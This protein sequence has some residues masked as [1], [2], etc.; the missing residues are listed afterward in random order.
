MCNLRI[1]SGTKWWGGLRIAFQQ[2]DRHLDVFGARASGFKLHQ[3]PV[4]QRIG[5]FGG[6]C[7]LGPVAD[8]F[9]GGALAGLP[10]DLLAVEL[11]LIAVKGRIKAEPVFAVLPDGE[12]ARGFAAAL[13]A[14]RAAYLRQDWDT[15][16]QGFA[17]IAAI[18]L[19]G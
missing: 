7:L 8:G 19:P 1:G 17:E 9:G 15:A 5:G 11:D 12:T 13:A 10:G 14:A 4:D 6:A 18:T 3:R 16:E 2:G